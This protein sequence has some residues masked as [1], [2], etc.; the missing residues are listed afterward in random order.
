[1][2]PCPWNP[3]QFI[4]SVEVLHSILHASSYVRCPCKGHGIGCGSSSWSPTQNMTWY[5]IHRLSRFIQL[6]WYATVKCPRTVSWPNDCWRTK[7]SQGYTGTNRKWNWWDFRLGFIKLTFRLQ[8]HD[9]LGTVQH[10]I[11]TLAA[12]GDTHVKGTT[13]AVCG[14]FPIRPTQEVPSDMKFRHIRCHFNL[15]CQQK[16][17]FKNEAT[18]SCKV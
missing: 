13:N 17:E 8:C 9:W 12:I 10:P 7:S 16:T 18:G 1:M 5:E 14:S 3:P 11:S 4:D 6:R 15:Q 2:A